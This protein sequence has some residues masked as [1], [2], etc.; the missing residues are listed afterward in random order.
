MLGPGAAG[1]STFAV[2]LAEVSGLP[3]VELDKSFWGVDLA[4]L[5]P[6]EWV[7][8]QQVLI[9]RPEWILDGDLGPYDVLDTRLG[10]ADT[11]VVLALPLRVCLWRALRRSHERWDFWRWL[12][13]WRRDSLPLL[14]KALADTG[15]DV[16]FLRSQ[17]DVE[18][19]LD[20]RGGTR[21]GGTGKA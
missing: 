6:G 1:K 4:P 8:R 18:A 5:T 12:L 9:E 17:R 2:R 20:R 3:A 19:F 21:L 16:H 13:R 14:E 7:A 10:A 15:A 11:V